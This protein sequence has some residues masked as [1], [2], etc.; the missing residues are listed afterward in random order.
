MGD[1]FQF[2]DLIFFGIVA[3]FLVMRLRSVLG[4]RTGAERHR[5]PFASAPAK[6]QTAAARAP[7]APLPDISAKPAMGTP[8]SGASVAGGLTRIRSADPAFDEGH[9][10]SGARSA[11]E[12]IVNAYASGDTAALKPLL[13]DDV[14][15]N[16]ANA[17]EDRRKSGH[18]HATTL[19]GVRGIDI[20]EAELQ[21]RNAVITVKILSDQIN[22]TR[23]SDGKTVDGD[24]G[25][26][27]SVTDIWTF[28]RST[29]ARD[30]NWTLVATRSP[31]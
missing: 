3:V 21:A 18:T 23:D 17:I 14:F 4:R 11:F 26:V 13:S 6:D 10:L 30:P 20:I 25:E 9:F 1:G 7:S 31:Q 5:D 27:V 15:A 16:F 12:I 29:R 22:V 2:W 24:P 8:A 19:V 28:S